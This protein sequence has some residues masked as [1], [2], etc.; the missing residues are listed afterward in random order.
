[1]VVREVV[2]PAVLPFDQF[3]AGWARQYRQDQHVTIIGPTGSGKTTLATELVKPRGHVVALGVKHVDETL[4]KLTRKGSEWHRVEQW[5]R[6]PKSANRV[7]LWPKANDLD[8]VLQV[9]HDTFSD[10]FRSVYKIGHWT[11]WMDELTYLTDHC[12][13]RKP[14]RS[15]YILARSNRVSLVGV[16]Q[17][18]AHI[19][20]EA[21]SQASHLFMYRTGDERDLARQGGLNGTNAKQVAATVANLPPH[22]FLHVNLLTGQQTISN[23]E[24]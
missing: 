1:M 10:L 18:P 12:G 24:R 17:R 11:L 15:L 19:P 8:K 23:T 5:K 22:T 14:I 20:L 16:A 7:V 21:Y 4:A 13:L 3:I 6:R 2:E 9:H